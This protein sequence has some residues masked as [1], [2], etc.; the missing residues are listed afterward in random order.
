LYKNALFFRGFPGDFPGDFPGISRGLFS[1][2]TRIFGDFHPVLPA[3][4]LLHSARSG[5]NPQI[6]GK[7]PGDFRNFRESLEKVSRNF[8]K[9]H[10]SGFSEN[11]PEFPEF[12][13]RYLQ[14]LTRVLP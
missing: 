11:F 4:T 6:S 5:K 1:E 7:V 9:F 10:P 13:E 2:K 14:C 3:C 12:W 8:R